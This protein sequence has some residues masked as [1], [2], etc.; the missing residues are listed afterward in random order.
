MVMLAPASN[1]DEVRAAGR[2]VDL[3]EGVVSPVEQAAVGPQRET[4]VA[5][6]RDCDEVGTRR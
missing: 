3:A 6:G 4:V 5:A 2:A 1:R